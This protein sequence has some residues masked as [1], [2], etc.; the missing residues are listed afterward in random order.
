MLEHV[1][2]LETAVVKLGVPPQDELGYAGKPLLCS[3]AKLDLTF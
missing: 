1:G 3:S 2:H